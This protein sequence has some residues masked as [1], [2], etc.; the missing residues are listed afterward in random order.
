M[1]PFL[2]GPLTFLLITLFLSLPSK[3]L[4]LTWVT[5]PLEP[6]LPITSSTFAGTAFEKFTDLPKSVDD[7]FAID[8]E[9]RDFLRIKWTI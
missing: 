7:V 3:T 8:E 1:S 2:T 9:V 4:H 5:S 6:V